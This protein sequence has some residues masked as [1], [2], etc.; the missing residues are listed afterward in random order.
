MRLGSMHF[1][2]AVGLAASALLVTNVLAQPAAAPVPAPPAAAE[3]APAPVA[4]KPKKRGPTP[5]SS[6]IV[7]N[8]SASTATEVVITGEDKTAKTS[9]PLSPKA[10]VTVK[11]PRL[12]GCTVSVAATF[13]GEGQADVGEFDVCKD[14]NI[15]F[16]D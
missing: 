4:A 6:V 16:T 11:L 9:K 15:R 10:K 3:A 2:L 1:G 13:E 8:A 7:T 12:K 5:A 14:R